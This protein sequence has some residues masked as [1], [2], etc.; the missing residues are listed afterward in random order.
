MLNQTRNESVNRTQSRANETDDSVAE[1]RTKPI[2]VAHL[3]HSMAYGGVET[4]LINWFSNFDPQRVE[5]HLLCFANPGESER[6]FVEAASTA[7]L[8]VATI[9]WGRHKPIWRA[10]KLT[11]TWLRE[12]DIE[13]LHCHNTYAN[14]VGLVAA[15]M[16]P[17]RTLTTVY[18]WSSFGFKRRILQWL[19]LCML[20]FFDQV[21]AH[22]EAALADTVNRG[23]PKER[24]RLLTCGFS[25][26]VAEMDAALRMAGRAELGAQPDDTVLIKVARFWPEK[27]HD[28]LL[29]AFKLL[30]ERQPNILLLIPGI[31]P[32]L[33]KNQALA[34]NLGICKRCRFLG[35][36]TDLPELLA[37]ADIQ[38]HTSDE[39]GVPLAILSGMAAGIPIVSTAVGGIPEVIKHQYSGIL[40]PPA[41]PLVIAD[42]VYELMQDPIRQQRL[43]KAAQAFI[44]NEYSLKAATTRVEDLYIE[45][46]GR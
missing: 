42:A 20:R 12:H 28:I 30:L 31:G 23:M 6:P 26:R 19:D 9:P 5:T 16:A 10:A 18:V 17:I 22:C 43:G 36:R 2:R 32:E 29:Q 35:F 37:M 8:A 44:E 41:S 21:T 39:E 3:I 13:L 46:A 1:V 15:R 38:V 45:V 25:E 14:M 40:V 27:R 11:A 7:G 24:I 33:E 4:A 34:E